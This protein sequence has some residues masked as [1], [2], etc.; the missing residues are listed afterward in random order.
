M[1]TDPNVADDDWQVRVV[2]TILRNTHAI[3]DDD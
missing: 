2:D 1:G 3:F